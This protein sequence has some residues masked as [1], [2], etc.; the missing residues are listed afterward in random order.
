MEY[1]L[2][3]NSAAGACMP[4]HR[5]AVR[6]W[7]PK[8]GAEAPPS[9]CGFSKASRHGTRGGFLRASGALSG[10][11]LRSEPVF[12]RRELLFPLLRRLAGEVHEHLQRRVAF[13]VEEL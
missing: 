12:Q 5:F 13:V 11:R 3:A 6:P 9:Q 8:T 10:F 4:T 2:G 7:D 1:P